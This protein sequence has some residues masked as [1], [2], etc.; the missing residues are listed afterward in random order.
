VDGWPN[1]TADI[2]YKD[3]IIE[4]GDLNRKIWYQGYMC[5]GAPRR[6]DDHPGS[7]SSSQ[8]L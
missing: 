5:K 6:Q 8:R 3:G 4:E 2:S 1:Y 7:V